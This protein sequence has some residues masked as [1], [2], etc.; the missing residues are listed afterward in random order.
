VDGT[1]CPT[2]DWKHIPDLYSKKAG[3]PGM[4][5]QIACNLDGELAAIGPEPVHGAYA[6]AAS[7]LK[8]LM[9]AIHTL[10]DLG[11]AGRGHRPRPD[12]APT[13]AGT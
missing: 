6:Y 5:V 10:A 11:H 12:Q 4:N 13:R 3:Y 1:V 8:E 9:A 2:W 7:G